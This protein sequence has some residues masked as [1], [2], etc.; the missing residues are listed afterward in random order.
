M[1]Y[2][3]GRR[4]SVANAESWSK[5]LTRYGRLQHSVSLLQQTVCQN[6]PDTTI[7]SV[8][9]V[10][11]LLPCLFPRPSIGSNYDEKALA[12]DTKEAGA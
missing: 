7:A 8:L 5:M 4:L 6:V 3:N 2:K 1:M 9:S 11:D 12:A 10:H